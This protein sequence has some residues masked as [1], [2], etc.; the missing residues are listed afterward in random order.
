MDLSILRMFAEWGCS[1][2]ICTEFKNINQCNNNY[3]FPS[4]I[5]NIFIIENLK[6]SQYIAVLTQSQLAQSIGGLR[7]KD[8][9]NGGKLVMPTPLKVFFYYSAV[10]WEQ[11]M[12]ILSI[13]TCIQLNQPSVIIS[14]Q[15]S[16]II[17][18]QILYAS[19]AFLVSAPG[20]WR[21]KLPMDIKFC[22]NIISIAM[23]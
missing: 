6:L 7:N 18:F 9:Y 14:Y 3:S 8:S 10:I 11:N 16:A 21:I 2:E 12:F 15:I 20:M 4:W 17:S 22:L 23:F 1:R 5:I 19:R 13:L